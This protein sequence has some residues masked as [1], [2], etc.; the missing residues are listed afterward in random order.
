MDEAEQ[1]YDLHA[2]PDQFQ[3]LG[4]VPAYA[5]TRAECRQR[6]LD[7]FAGLKRRTTVTCEDVEK[8]TNAYKKA[9]VF[10]GQW[11]NRRERKSVVSGTSVSVRVDCGGGR[12]L[13][14]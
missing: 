2:D 12:V 9:G 3:D 14:K 6:L 7:W 4:Q 11:G 5:S 10:V 1:L 8:G 13:Q